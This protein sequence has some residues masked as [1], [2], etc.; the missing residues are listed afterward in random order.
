MYRDWN[1]P[2]THFHIGNRLRKAPSNDQCLYIYFS[3]ISNIQSF[4]WRYRRHYIVRSLDHQQEV[5]CCWLGN[6]NQEVPNNDCSKRVWRSMLD[7]HLVARLFPG[8]YLEV[9]PWNPGNGFLRRT[10]RRNPSKPKVSHSCSS[11]QSRLTTSLFW[12]FRPL[13]HQNAFV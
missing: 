2:P 12:Y 11:A 8:I 3:K 1:K 5:L 7:R 10:L 9:A 13:L 4:A 6:L